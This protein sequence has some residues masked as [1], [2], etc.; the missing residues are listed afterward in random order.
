VSEVPLQFDDQVGVSV[1]RRLTDE[2]G[3]V[4]GHPRTN[5][6]RIALIWEAVLGVGVSPEQV[7]LCLLGVKLARLVETPDDPDSIADLAGYAATLEL[8][9]GKVPSV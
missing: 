6:A 4:Y 9:A 3:R 7:G 1:G 8:L 5:F 2:R